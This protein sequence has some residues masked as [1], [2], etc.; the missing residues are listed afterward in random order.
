MLGGYVD[1][2]AGEMQANSDKAEDLCDLLPYWDIYS[3]QSRPSFEDFI[4]IAEFSELEGPR[5]WI[6]IPRETD[7]KFDL[8]EFSIR[9]MSVDYHHNVGSDSFHGTEDTHL[10]MTEAQKG[11]HTYVH[12]FTLYDANARGYV[13]PFC[14]SYVTTDSKKLT[15]FYQEISE[16]LSSVCRLFKYGSLMRFEQDLKE[17]L[18]DLLFTKG[19][20]LLWMERSQ[21]AECDQQQGKPSLTDDEEILSNTNISLLDHT[22][23]EVSNL[24]EKIV[25]LKNEPHLERHF[26]S[27]HESKYEDSKENVMAGSY[28]EKQPHLKGQK[29]RS[30]SF[31]HIYEKC[32]PGKPSPSQ[33]S[34]R[35]VKASPG[36][37]FE[38]NLRTLHELCHWGAKAGLNLLRNVHKKL[39][40][41]YITLEIERQ[42]QQLAA[43]SDGIL[44]VGQTVTG[45]IHINQSVKG[46]SLQDD[47]MI[48]SP[49]SP[50][51]SKW[52]SSESFQSAESFLSCDDESP[53][54]DNSHANSKNTD[55]FI[56]SVS[57]TYNIG[58]LDTFCNGYHHNQAHVD[59]PNIFNST[60]NTRENFVFSGG[61]DLKNLQ[62]DSGSLSTTDT[63]ATPEDMSDM[64]NFIIRL[65]S[66]I[67]DPDAGVS[68]HSIA[69]DSTACSSD[70]GLLKLVQNYSFSNKLIYALLSSRPVIVLGTMSSEKQVQHWVSDLAKFIPGFFYRPNCVRALQKDSLTLVD[71]AECRIIGLIQQDKKLTSH[72]IPKAVKKLVT[73]FDVDNKSLFSPQ[74]KGSLVNRFTKAKKFKSE[75]AYLTCVHSCL[76]NLSSLAY[77]FYTT[78][79]MLKSEDSELGFSEFEQCYATF[80]KKFCMHDHDMQIIQNIVNSIIHSNLIKSG[81]FNSANRQ[82]SWP[83]NL[84]ILKN[85]VDEQVLS[86]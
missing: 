72:L 22:I 31:S 18:E 29:P 36:R 54:Q 60:D 16:E 80:S 65:R 68:M 25:S 69:H 59:I 49:F 41:D 30:G 86:T 3:V 58:N 27:L 61:L 24:H 15:S 62:T 42:D 28:Q 20:Y 53:S 79:C 75:G 12:H 67:A 5:P 32:F 55:V 6:T 51:I 23:M 77:V 52:L 56:N 84:D 10:L 19:E 40:R 14:L 9:I 70:F 71:I 47:F 8:N 48:I 83:W 73:I 63:S 17:R 44:T 74:Y 76:T 64:S 81:Q 50:S 26:S 2:Y 13:R 4:L 33:S 38:K 82:F 78:V 37:L 45:N 39:S 35:I 85:S 57:K 11:I 1:R 46:I 21:L 66:Q 34:P 43:P 7:E